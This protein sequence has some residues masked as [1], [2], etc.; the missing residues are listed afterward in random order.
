MTTD[1]SEKQRLRKT[2]NQANWVTRHYD[3]DTEM[4]QVR[5]FTYSTKIEMYHVCCEIRSD[6]TKDQ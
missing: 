6:G 5:T 4:P 1:I 3:Q 2:G